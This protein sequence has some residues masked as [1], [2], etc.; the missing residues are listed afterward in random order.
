M[1]SSTDEFAVVR[2]QISLRFADVRAFWSSAKAQAVPPPQPQP[3]SYLAGSGFTIVFLYAAL[4]FAITRGVKQ[5]SQLITA[6]P[7]RTKDVSTPIMCLVHDPKV[8]AIRDAGRKTRLDAR[9]RLFTAV[10][11]P[12]T[13]KIHDELLAPELQNV[14]FK[15]ISDTFQMFG[16][17]DYPLNDAASEALI[18][19]IVNDRNAV[20]HGRESPDIVGSRYTS[21]D[22]DAL[23]GRI[24]SE[25][26]FIINRFADFYADRRF[27]HESDRSRY[28][29]REA[30]A[31]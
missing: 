24:E 29:K 5:L 30:R 6:Y 31:P 13:A 20:A 7:V 11:S 9:L 16:I 23:V 10:K 27:I 22:I 21:G 15:S 28:L 26:Q 25:G 4:E 1:P 14:W 2:Q 18:D 12:D 3:F 17:S 19:R 8:N